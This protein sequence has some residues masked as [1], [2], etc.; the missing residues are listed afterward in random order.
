[1]LGVVV[2]V[3]VIVVV[4]LEVMLGIGVSVFVRVSSDVIISLSGVN[5]VADEVMAAI[6]SSFSFSIPKLG[7]QLRRKPTKVMAIMEK[8]AIG[9]NLLNLIMAHQMY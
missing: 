9:T 5:V 2:T 7:L 1:M 6:Y 8:A 4:E 3:D